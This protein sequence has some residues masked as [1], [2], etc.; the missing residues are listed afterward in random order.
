M[1]AS[2]ALAEG[3]SS[4]FWT[5]IEM[6]RQSLKTDPRVA[7]ATFDDFFRTQ[8][9]GPDGIP[10]A[11]L[12]RKREGAIAFYVGDLGPGTCTGRLANGPN[13]SI[14]INTGCTW[15]AIGDS[16]AAAGFEQGYG[17]PSGP[18]YPASFRGERG[19]RQLFVNFS[20]RNLFDESWVAFWSERTGEVT[21]MR[22]QFE[23]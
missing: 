14:I 23:E 21:W 22:A 9:L 4:W 17:F 2:T 12:T 8:L 5:E 11:D 20:D 13:G 19:Q 16:W 15:G 18:E 10:G 3:V 1:C 7:G 6:A